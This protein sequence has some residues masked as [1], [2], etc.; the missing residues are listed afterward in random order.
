MSSFGDVLCYLN[1]V[2]TVKNDIP[3]KKTLVLG[4]LFSVLCMTSCQEIIPSGNITEVRH[5]INADFIQI[6]VAAGITFDISAGASDVISVE[7][8]DNMQEFISVSNQQDVLNIGV[9][10]GN[11]NL[12]FTSITVH[13]QTKQELYALVLQEGSHGTV[14][15]P[16][17]GIGGQLKL[18][19]DEGSSLEADINAPNGEAWLELGGGSS[20]NLTGT[21]KD[22]KLLMDGG[23]TLEAYD[24]TMKNLIAQ[25]FEG[26]SHANVTVTDNI[27]VPSADGGSTLYYKG[28]AIVDSRS[29]FSGGSSITNMN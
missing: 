19:T 8:D 20:M 3:M 7:T 5:E 25:V 10:E 15:V 16:L 14:N 27:Y 29:S 4:F 22:V 24:L 26:S 1:E 23:G 17:T 9:K 12:S 2:E 18:N 13:I 11:T 21:V 28:T 6:S